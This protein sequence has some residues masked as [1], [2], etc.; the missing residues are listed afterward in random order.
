MLVLECNCN[1]TGS[2]SAFCEPSGGACTCKEKIV[3]RTC[4]HC[5]YGTWGFGPDGCTGNILLESSDT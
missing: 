5:A 2:V 4:D 3:G 1:L